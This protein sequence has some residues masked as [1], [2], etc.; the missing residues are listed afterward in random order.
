L[1]LDR[2][3]F[4][5][6][7]GGAAAAAALPGCARSSQ[8]SSP[9]DY[10]LRI[11]TGLVETATNRIVSTTLYNNQFPG[12][13]IRLREGRSVII[14]VHNDTD[15]PEQLHWHGQL[16]PVD[17]DGSAE[18]GTPF[19]PAHGRRR[20][21]FTP[22]P[23]GFR[24]YHSHRVAGVDLRASLYSGQLGLVYIEPRNE[25]GAYDREL[26]LVLKEFNPSFTHLD[27]MAMGFLV[28]D[29]I[30]KNLEA[31]GE[32]AH[33]AYLA[34]GMTRGFEVQY[35]NFSING[36]SL[37]FGE[38]IRVKQNERVMFH[39][40]NG[41]ATEV[42]SLALPGHTFRVIA[43]DGNPVPTPADVPVLWIAPGER[44]TALVQMSHPGVW[45]LGDLDE[46]RY[47]GMGVVVEYAGATG[48]AQWE[49]PPSYTWDYSMFG[50]P[51]TAAAST[52]DQTIEL[53][54]RKENG[55]IDGFNRWLINDQAFSMA[56][57]TP[58]FH[59][60]HGRRY[61]LRMRN[62]SE[63]VHPI[64]L[65]RHIFELTRIA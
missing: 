41:S 6:L 30:D 42:R 36:K 43:L 28:P 20:L 11:A 8:T 19:I 33:M 56:D 4:L 64:H 23:A 39:V 1:S 54:F 31:I 40:L 60:E 44:V 25:P 14:D 21:T 24:F 7:T 17:V 10:T 12:P 62:A 35:A 3:A 2:R 53:M 59:L 49:E 27:D 29:E 13:L 61:R 50:R 55:A 46:D 32:S 52:P 5:K 47:R 63:D 16:L 37:E 22:G 57:M 48:R 26:F 38:P 58:R 65:H 15:V 34:K 51:S 45:V 18:E 9:A